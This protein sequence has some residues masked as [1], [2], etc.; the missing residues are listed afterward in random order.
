MLEQIIFG[1]LI[2]TIVLMIYFNLNKD[3]KQIFNIAWGII[4]L[5][6]WRN[7]GKCR[8]NGLTKLLIFRFR[9]DGRKP[10]K[11]YTVL[12]DGIKPLRKHNENTLM[13][14]QTKSENKKRFYLQL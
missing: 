1:L 2:I 6:A 7:T 13:E 11:W 8:A 3:L 4:G 5:L 10:L 12:E 9:T 14:K